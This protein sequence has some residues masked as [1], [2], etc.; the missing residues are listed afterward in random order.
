MRLDFIEWAKT[1]PRFIEPNFSAKCKLISGFS[2]FVKSR[3]WNTSC[4]AL[5][6]VLEQGDHLIPIPGTRS[7]VHLKEWAG[8][9]EIKLT[10]EDRTEI[11]QIL[12]VGFVHG[13]RYSDEQIVGI[14]RY[15]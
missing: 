3:G 6:W 4:A 1:Q 8:A 7:A 10:N 11:E 5:A 15:C 2:K 14:E 12:P 13:D 9:A